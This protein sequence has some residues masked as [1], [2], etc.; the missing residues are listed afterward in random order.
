MTRALYDSLRQP[1]PLSLVPSPIARSGCTGIEVESVA[2]TTRLFPHFPGLRLNQ[3][4]D[5]CSELPPETDKVSVPIS[6]PRPRSSARGRGPNV[7]AAPWPCLLSTPR[8]RR[9]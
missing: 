6:R 2:I 4:S 8:A 9:L 1:L 7:N 3:C 5:R